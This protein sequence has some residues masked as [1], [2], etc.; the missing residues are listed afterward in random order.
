M[1][2]KSVGN[3]LLCSD[4]IRSKLDILYGN[5]QVDQKIR[6]CISAKKKRIVLVILAT[7]IMLAI[8]VIN[9]RDNSARIT[10]IDRN[11][12]G[13]GSKTVS[14]IAKLGNSGL[15]EKITFNVD[16]KKY[17]EEEI[18][19]FEEKIISELE[20]VILG[21]NT[22]IDNVTSNLMLISKLEGYPFN[23]SWKSE[24]PLLINSS[25]VI[26]KKKV[27]EE[28]GE[29]DEGIPVMLCAT[30]TYDEYKSDNYFYAVVKSDNAVSVEDFVEEITDAIA[31]ADHDSKTEDTLEL[32]GRVDGVNLY[33]FNEKSYKGMLIITIG[34]VC[35][36]GLCV[37]YDKDVDKKL[38]ERQK[39]MDMDYP[40]ILSQ[41]ALYYCAGM[42]H[43]S[44][45]E[46][47]CRKYEERSA[48]EKQKRYAYEEM[49]ITRRELSE[50]VGEITAYESFA[51][52]C[53]NVK[54][55]VFVNLIEQAVRKGNNSL[56]ELLEEEVEKARREDNNRIRMSAQE[57]STKLLFP[58]VMMLLIVLVIVMVPA[59][60]SMNK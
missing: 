43:R 22:S 58:M 30:L 27:K 15:Y 31:V 5:C 38:N 25:G 34:I 60:I 10:S 18:K 16:E 13:E 49:L 2:N 26:N 52:R 14:L 32:P 24:K 44:I 41:Y 3:N 39:E 35:A 4:R 55:R 12:Y 46:E 28:A 59:F 9:E 21:N 36:V 23:I 51:N 19:D 42:N 20:A 7:M 57:L 47:I 50:G 1:Q 53:R 56:N 33:Y 11:A 8:T 17:S 6:E 48:V 54:Y 29:H 40:G 45:W 37:A